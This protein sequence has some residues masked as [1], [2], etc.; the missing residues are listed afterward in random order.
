MAASL[1]QVYN[2][3]KR[4]LLNGTFD[5]DTNVLRLKLANGTGAANVSNYARS[6]FASISASVANMTHKTL[7]ALSV[8]VGASAK[9][10]RFDV[11]D[12]VLTAGGAV[13]SV[14]YAI[15]GVSAGKALCW[16]KLST[17]AFSVSSGNTL[18][19]TINNS[20]V[21]ELTGGTTA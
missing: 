5:L 18:T 6:T 21:F 14:Q 17:V 10:A 19:I 8:T 20:G 15:I 12:V 9:V 1:W 2:S 13:T 16:C 7:A 3:A 11:G 4:N